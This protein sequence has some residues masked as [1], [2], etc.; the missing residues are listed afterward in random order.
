MEIA[1][2]SDFKKCE[3]HFDYLIRAKKLKGL[4][5]DGRATTAQP[6]TTKRGQITPEQQLRWHTTVE[7]ALAE[8]RRLNLPAEEFDKVCDHFFGNLDESCFMA[9]ADGK[10]KVIASS[11]KKKTEKITDDCRSSITSVRVGFAS[12]DEGPY[13]FLAKGQE[14]QRA[15]LK[16]DLSKSSVVDAP[17]G[18][19]VVMSP[20]AYMTDEVYLKLVTPLC[21]GIRQM[22][23]IKDHPDWWVILSMD[24]FGSH[25]NVH[26]AQEIFTE[27]KIFVIKE[28][29]DTSQVNQAYDQQVAKA[30]KANMRKNLE[31]VRSRLGGSQMD[32]WVL[33]KLAANAQSKVSRDTWI[34]SHNNVNTNPKTRLPF[35]DWL[36]KLDSK[37][38]LLSGEHFFQRKNLYDAMPA[39][40]KKLSVED[41]HS[42]IGI[43]KRVYEAAEEKN[44][45]LLWKTSDVKELAKY[46]ALDDIYKLRACYLTSKIDP[47]VIVGDTNEDEVIDTTSSNVATVDDYFTFMPNDLV[48][49]FK[50]DAT[51]LPLVAKED[52]AARR[53]GK[54]SNVASNEPLFKSTVQQKLFEH[55]CNKACES[56]WAN[57][58]GRQLSS[59][60]MIDMSKEQQQLVNP[61]YKNVLMG[62]ISYDV[63]GKG[64]KQKIASRRLNMIAGNV[65]S[66]SRCLNDPKSLQHMKEMN[67]LIATVATVTADQEKEKAERKEAAA[68][69]EMEKKQKK[70]DEEA[71]DTKK[72]Q[73]LLPAL[74][75]TMAKFETGEFT[76]PASFEAM[77]KTQLVNIMRY[78]YEDKPKG[79]ATMGKNK[80]VQLVMGHFDPSV[81]A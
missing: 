61:S 3:N 14:I 6:T 7:N 67:Q 31:L 77:P 8:Q 34:G 53:L 25:V 28:E 80:L 26:E 44:E 49:E 35:A 40:W 20:N 45:P 41:R 70:K 58:N 21:H 59:H 32:Q 54:G 5:R 16:G 79:L 63:K 17:V 72:K 57:E 39:V 43:I 68:A 18:S 36:K 13:I 48:K 69:R 30:D 15:S 51:A 78:F 52:S 62:F 81:S 42:V 47:G 11:D 75:E 12:G 64:A 46:V 74:E 73:Q 37:G 71:A 76:A 4:K 22:P 38:I 10:V 66:Y 29:G 33:I 23:V 50:K 1:Q 19:C 2:S 27:H 9:N 55:M 56:E 24:G 60:L 65:A